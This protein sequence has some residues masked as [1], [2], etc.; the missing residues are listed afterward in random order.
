MSAQIVP[1]HDNEPSIKIVEVTPKLAEKWLGKNVQ[2]RNLRK[3]I[4][5][6]LVRD[7]RN[8]DFQL[9]GE[10]IKFDTNGNL[11]D[12]QH[13]LHAIVLSGITAMMLVVT[14]IPTEAMGTIDAGAKRKFSDLL[15]IR[16]ETGTYAISAIARRGYL[17]DKGHKS[18]TGAI[19]PTTTEMD[20]WLS[21]NPSANTA[22][23]LSSRLGSRK[24]LPPSIIGL[25]YVLFSRID[26]EQ[27]EYFLEHTA[28]DAEH[29]LE[30]GAD[31]ADLRSAQPAFSLRKKIKAL[32]ATGGR[33]NETTALAFTILAWNSWRKGDD[34][35]AYRMPKNG[36]GDNLPE[37]K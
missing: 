10:T 23:Q 25:C 33:V 1:L 28:H 32:R 19:V 7:M 13:R 22:A 15:Q 30:R 27:A 26:A 16:G 5:A 11:L 3:N 29:F 2:N 24:V 35:N 9:N 36:W 18:N 8:G 20:E 12:G 14:G 34:R 4:V 17:W 6:A 37:P 31:T 21:A